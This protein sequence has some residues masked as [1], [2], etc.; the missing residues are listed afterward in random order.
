MRLR[1][2]A[3]GLPLS[4]DREIDGIVGMLRASTVNC[5]DECQSGLK[6]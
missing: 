3:D 6:N 1:L 4:R 2:V 5:M